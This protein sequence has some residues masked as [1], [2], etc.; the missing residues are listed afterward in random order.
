MIAIS[1]CCD[2]Q[3]FSRNYAPSG[4][5][6]LSK[7]TF[8]NSAEVYCDMTTD[9]G[10]W[11]VIQRNKVKSKLDFKKSWVAYEE[12]FGDPKTDHE[13][14]YGLNAMHCF[15]ETGQW[16]MRVDYQK[17]DKTW[18]YLHYSQ[19]SVASASKKYQLTAKG[20]IGEG[21]D[22]FARHNGMKFSTT[23][24]YANQSNAK[25]CVKGFKIS[26][27]YNNCHRININTQPPYVFG[28]VLFTEMKIRPKDCNTY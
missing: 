1:S 20:F 2:L 10:G 17:E 13:F 4:M 12:G 14:W 21:T 25:N 8:D 6:K 22:Q 18:S 23:D 24:N 7:G 27:W 11:I 3:M 9:G 26:W 28:N 15:T 19:F 5:Y 16:E